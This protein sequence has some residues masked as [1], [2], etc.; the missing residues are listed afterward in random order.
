VLH[1]P[2]P[3]PDTQ[4]AN[5]IIDIRNGKVTVFEGDYDSYLYWK[6]SSYPEG[7]I[8]PVS[9][10]TPAKPGVTRREHKAREGELRNKYYKESSP[11]RNRSGEVE[12]E[13]TKLRERLGEV[14]VLLADPEQYRDSEKAAATVKEYNQLTDKIR[15]LT[16][17]RVKLT[18]EIENLKQKYGIAKDEAGL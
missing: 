1:H 9:T 13:I 16:E 4:I 8:T 15:S 5:K 11:L 18:G 7:R 6:D 10:Q 2:R 12:K 14:E 3:D 17:E